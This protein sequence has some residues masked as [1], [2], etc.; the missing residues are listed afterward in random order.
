[1]TKKAAVTAGEWNVSE[2]GWSWGW[3]LTDADGNPVPD[4]ITRDIAEEE[5]RIFIFKGTRQSGIPMNSEDV[6][7]NT[8]G[9]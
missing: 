8:M 1:M 5:N 3:N 6:E 9:I 2:T 7:I 4:G